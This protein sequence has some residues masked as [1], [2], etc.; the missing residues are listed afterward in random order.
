MHDNEHGRI[1][2]HLP[3]DRFG[4]IRAVVPIS[5]GLS[6]AGVYAVTT[7]AGE[8]VLR[9]TPPH[10]A[11]DWSRQLA[12]LRI[13]SGHGIAPPLAFVDEAGRA[14]VSQRI[15]GPRIGLVLTDPAVRDRA[16]ASLVTQLAGLHAIPDPGVERVDLAAHAL[17]LWRANFERP[18][19][20]RWALALDEEIARHGRIVASDPRHA[21]SHNDLNPGNLLWDGERIWLVD[22]SA[23]AMTHPYY[24]LATFSMFLQLPED[25][26]LALLTMQEGARP[27]PEQ[28][29]TFRAL[30]RLSG[31]L[32]GLTF[33]RLTADDAL[34]APD[35]IEDAPTMAQCYALMRSQSLDLQTGEGRRMFGL[36]LL[37]GALT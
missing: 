25:A 7:D 30:R 16:F 2:R 35:R 12:T 13:V 17:A 26:A 18:G 19:F 36:A 15:A 24:D 4:D 10:E 11:S 9:I 29:E 23:S 37:R 1:A 22:W 5:V 32:S 21:L 34:H 3:L 27:S 14:T 6:G 31:I 20:P 33:V 28:V 8:Y